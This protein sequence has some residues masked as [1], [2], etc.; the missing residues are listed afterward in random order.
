[1]HARLPR[2]PAQNQNEAGIDC[3]GNCTAP[4]STTSCNVDADC[5]GTRCGQDD[6]AG[7]AR[8]CQPAACNDGLTNG[9]E[10]GPDCGGGDPLCGRCIEGT[11]CLN[12]GDCASG[13]CEG[14]RCCG[15]T[16][17]DCTR[18]AERL[19]VGADCS[20]AGPASEGWCSA[21]LQCLANNPAAC[22]RRYEPGCSSDPGVCNH[23]FYGGD[24]SV[25]VQQANALIFSPG[26]QF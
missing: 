14:G 19:S 3:G 2:W 13:A 9:T 16:L 18:C 11:A 15:G 20:A 4:C 17:G 25:G 26:C 10:T 8:C 12:D 24:G 7:L 23:N 6:C 1:V 21:F 5:N 22:P